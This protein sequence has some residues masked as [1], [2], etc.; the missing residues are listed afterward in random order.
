MLG[1]ESLL[2]FTVLYK[3]S[4]KDHASFLTHPERQ[5]NG[6]TRLLHV[7]PVRSLADCSTAA[8]GLEVPDSAFC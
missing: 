4:A 2:L 1:H 5:C 8:V 7:A 3:N 6:L